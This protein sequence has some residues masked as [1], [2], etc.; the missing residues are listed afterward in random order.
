MDKKISFLIGFLGVI[1]L[2]FGIWYFRMIVT[3]ILIAAAISVI[4]QP[5]LKLINRIEFRNRKIP[6]GITASVTL[7]LLWALLIAFFKTL[8]PYIISETN[9]LSSIDVVTLLKNL[10]E[11]LNDIFILLQNH[12][13]FENQESFESY[14]TTKILSIFSTS[15]ITN[16]ASGLTSIFGNLIIAAFA[17]SFITFFFLKDAT[18]FS[19][20][21]LILVPGNHEEEVSHVLKSIRNLLSKYIIGLFLEVFM[22]MLLVTFGLWLVGIEFQHAIICGLVS[23]ILN[24]IPYVGPWIG[25][26]FGIIIG[27]ATNMHLPFQD[28]LLPLIGFMVLVYAIVQIIDNVLFQP[29]IYSSSVNAHPLEIFLVILMAGSMA[30]VG[31]MILAIPAYT[32]LRVIAKEFFSNSKVVQKITKNI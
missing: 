12:G 26:A 9:V 16:I 13:F 28:E 10:E 3:Y 25:A 32:V 1:L 27:I 8:V 11:P 19:N 4:G 17:I 23:G 5:F 6:I 2:I 18:L 21:V 7:I 24:I 20:G 22:V 30:G 15:S 29:L 31:G 14:L